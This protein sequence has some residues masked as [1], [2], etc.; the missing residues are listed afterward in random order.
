VDKFEYRRGY[1]F[2]TYATW[3]IRQ[4]ITRALA[5]QSRTIRIPVHLIDLRGRIVRAARELLQELGYEPCAEEIAVRVNIPEEKV[6]AI[7]RISKEPLSLEA[8]AGEDEEIHLRDFIEDKTTLSPIDIVMNDNLKHH[9]EQILCTL[10]PKEQRII[11][12]R[13]GIGE[14]APHTLEELGEEFDVTRERI[15]QIE[16]KAIK[17]LKYPAKCRWLNGFLTA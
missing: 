6:R 10:S 9:I 2:S 4:S 13:Y 5:D 15:R 12:M 7:L 8:P 17:K 3:W 1:K 14:D 16:V 11:R